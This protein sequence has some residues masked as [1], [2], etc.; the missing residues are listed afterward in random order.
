MLIGRCEDAYSFLRSASERGI[1]ATRLADLALLRPRFFHRADR[2]GMAV[3]A[4]HRDPVQDKDSIRRSIHYPLGFLLR[5]GT[6]KWALKEVASRYVPAQ[7]VHRKK[8]A[9][10]LPEARYLARLAR[11]E[12]FRNG[13]CADF[14]R[15]DADAIGDFARLHRENPH[16]FFHLVCVETWGRLFHKWETEEEMAGLLTR[17]SAGGRPGASRESTRDDSRSGGER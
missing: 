1:Q 8:I 16:S 9:W 2:L 17:R 10:A 14:F 4:E 13:F 15:L 3:S 6:N 11:P 7:I 12:L 5:R